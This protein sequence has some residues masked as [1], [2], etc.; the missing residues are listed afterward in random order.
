MQHFSVM[1]TLSKTMDAG[2]LG[3]ESLFS[4]DLTVVQNVLASVQ[5]NA[6]SLSTN[7]SNCLGEDLDRT[8]VQLT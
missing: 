7:N 4:M 1:K 6:A 3:E 5:N 2:K 8:T